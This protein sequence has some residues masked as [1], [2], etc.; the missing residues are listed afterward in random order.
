MAVVAG[1]FAAWGAN[2]VMTQAACAQVGGMVLGAKAGLTEEQ[3]TA[4][5]AANAWPGWPQKPYLATAVECESG[6]F[7][8]FDAHAGVPIER[9]TAASCAVPGLFP[10][11]TIDGKHYMDGGVRSGTSADLAQR[12]EPDITLIVAPLGRGA[13]RVH[14]LWARQIAREK[15]ELEAAGVAVRVI[16]FDDAAMAAGGA[17]LMDASLRIPTADAGEAH[18]RRIAPELQS[19]WRGR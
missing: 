10:P 18:A 8:V 14:L 5:F 17:N 11:V 4:S 12:I 15:G 2:D 19:W 6:A 1:V 13:G 16:Q 9:A 7:R 3:W